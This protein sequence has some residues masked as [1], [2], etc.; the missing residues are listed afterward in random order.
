MY[1]V[2][3]IF[4]RYAAQSD[5]QF[6][7]KAVV[8]SSTYD[9]TAVI[10]FTIEEGVIPSDEFVLGSVIA[11]K[12]TISI[13]TPDVISS[14]AKIIPYVRLCGQNKSF[15]SSFMPPQL[16]TQYSEWVPLGSFYIDTR[17]Y[18]NNVWRFTCYDKLIT[19]QQLYVSSLTYPVAMTS[20]FNELCTQLGY[21][22]DASVVIDPSYMIPY[23]D[24]EIS[25]RDM[26]G[27]IASVH[28]ACIRM[29]KDEKLAFVKFLPGSSRTSILASDYFKAEQTNP[30]KTFT[31]LRLTY[32]TDG[33]TLESGTGDDNHTLNIYNP[34]INQAML[35]ALLIQMNGYQQYAKWN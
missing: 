18:Q 5:R 28:G 17:S 27:F 22:I 25:M 10:E 30:A 3:N 9:K 34:F 33:E 7:I 29:T 19:S 32:N 4:K 26:L 11:S 13:R 15:L 2:S 16:F 23:K 14:N 12:L 24:E 35:D 20:V 31:R 1:S 6:E 8:G 21:T